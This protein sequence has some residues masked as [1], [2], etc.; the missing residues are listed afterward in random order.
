MNISSDKLDSYKDHQHLSSLYKDAKKLCNLNSKKRGIRHIQKQRSLFIRIFTEI[1]YCFKILKINISQK[2]TQIKIE[3]KTEK[4]D[5]LFKTNFSQKKWESDADEFL[6]E[7][8]RKRHEI[9]LASI[10]PLENYAYKRPDDLSKYNLIQEKISSVDLD[11]VV[12]TKNRGSG[13]SH[14]LDH[15]LNSKIKN[16]KLNDDEISELPQA[17]E[18]SS[19]EYKVH[20]MP[21][22]KHFLKV[23]NQLAELINSN[24]ELSEIIDAFKILKD[25]KIN[26]QDGKYIPNIVLY[27]KP[28]ETDVNNSKQNTEKALEIL[29]EAFKNSNSLG[30]NK[31]PRF[32][33]KVNSLIYYSQGNSDT[34]YLAKKAKMFKKIFDKNGIHFKGDGNKLNL[35]NKRKTE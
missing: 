23:V 19:R 35:Q 6:F 34:K 24:E 3:R 11:W 18:L 17:I 2:I 5:L 12:F 25:P 21:K 33:Q 1:P 29:N 20:L 30:S 22:P 4:I 9:I 27:I 10:K 32:N 7:I 14:D 28:S 26:K 13:L 16:K 31:K 8:A 15:L